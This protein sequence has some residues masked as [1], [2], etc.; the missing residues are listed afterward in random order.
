MVASTM[1][2]ASMLLMGLIATSVLAA[3][4]TT[5]LTPHGQRVATNVHEVPEDGE[6]RIV[7]Q[8]IHLLDASG[9]VVHVAQNDDSQIKATGTSGAADAFQTGW[10]AYADWYNEGSSP[11]SKFT[12]TWKVP[13]AP[14]TNNGQT[15]FLFN[16]I[17]PAS[18]NAILQPVLQY[19]PSAAGGG[20]YWAVASWYLVGSQTYYTTPVK[21]SAGA[22][23]D[24]VI[25]LDAS[26]DSKYNY[27]TSFSNVAKTSLKAS[28]AAELVWATETLEAYAITSIKDY[29][30]GST[31]FEDI[32]IKLKSGTPSVTW[33]TSSDSNDGITATVNTQGATNAKVTIKY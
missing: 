15:V 29:P 18:G 30:S 5:V 12:T 22:T 33:E 20:S 2:R 26:S 4:S 24:G 13:A 16:S 32:N 6:V 9:Q 31:V 23:L 11:I 25:T 7:G 19:G 28:N 10:I 17:E 27:T 21:T 8:E 14:A 1:L 3:P